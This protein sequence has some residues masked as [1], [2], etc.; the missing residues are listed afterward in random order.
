MAMRP[1]RSLVAIVAGP[2]VLLV[3]LHLGYM[4]ITR[5]CSQRPTGF[6]LL[7]ALLAFGV[8]LASG[9]VVWRF[10]VLTGGAHIDQSTPQERASFLSLT[11]LGTSLFSALAV[12]IGA[13]PLIVLAPPEAPGRSEL[14]NENGENCREIRRG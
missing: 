3:C 2:A 8:I 11:V 1:F 6:T 9:L 10:W 5:A 12:L 4:L 13:L 7:A 14:F